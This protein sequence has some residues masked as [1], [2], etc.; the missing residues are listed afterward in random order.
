[1]P[2]N[3][4]NDEVDP[5]PS[6]LAARLERRVRTFLRQWRNARSHEGL[7]RSGPWIVAFSGGPDSRALLEMV[8]ISFPR[9]EL[10]IA[11]M[12]HHA[13]DGADADEQFVRGLAK[14]YNLSCEV[15]HWRPIRSG[16][17][18]ADARKSRHEW[19]AGLA[20]QYQ[21]PAILTAHTQ[22]D[23]AETLLMRLA[24]GTGPAG[25]AGIRPW[26]RLGRVSQ[27]DLVRPVLK[28]TKREILQYLAEKE[29]GYC[30]DPTNAD[31]DHQSRAW[32]RHDLIPAVQARL[33]PC[34]NQA[35]ARLAELSAEEQDGIDQWIRRKTDQCFKP[36]DDR[37]TCLIDLSKYRRCGPGWIRRRVLRQI[38]TR[39]D[40]HQ[41]EMSMR[42]WVLADRFIASKES[43]TGSTLQ[44]P[45]L[46]QLVKRQFDL[47]IERQTSDMQVTSESRLDD[48]KII[49]VAWPGVTLLDDARL[50]IHQLEDVPSKDEILGFDPSAHAFI[51]D[52]NLLPPSYLR[53]P[54][55]G[56]RFDPLGMGGRH[57]HLVDFLRIQ[58]VA[59]DC[60]VKTWLLCDERG[61]IWVAGHRV[62][63]RVKITP[64]TSRAWHVTIKKIEG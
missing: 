15:G 47:L 24:R 23:Q 58:G 42:Q 60:K 14:E 19:L 63:D 37:Q 46:V 61:I 40:F 51:S 35:L 34:L 39:M 52:T 31:V 2:A 30:V 4:A 10:I 28:T 50:E 38:W 43:H 48:E 5:T 64:E 27:T 44:L 55:P 59:T 18:E 32:V 54:A 3:P 20:L 25:L 26:R 45:G 17:F 56:D 1:M 49:K 33:N 21:S 8:R 41:R 22:D 16:H 29:L 13:R 7:K 11:H 9:K 12:N 53:H 62:A 36:G 6:G 57:Q